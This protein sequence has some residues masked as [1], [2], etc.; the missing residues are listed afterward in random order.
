MTKQ[1][2][3]TPPSINYKPPHNIPH[4]FTFQKK[5][6]TMQKTFVKYSLIILLA[7]VYVNRGF[8]VTPYEIENHGNKEINSVVE[9]VLQLVTGE[10]NDIDEDGDAQSHCNSVKTVNVN[11]C[12]EIARYS[13]L[14]NIYSKNVGK[15]EFPNA[16]NLPLKDFCFQIDHPPQV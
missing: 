11:F 10:S 15:F 16:E 12:Q 7:V 13:D 8:F 14:L 9:W 2:Y 1:P 4:N 5:V 6:V 3:P